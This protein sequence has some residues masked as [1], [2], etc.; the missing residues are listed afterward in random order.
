M[1]SSPAS[2]TSREPHELIES[3]TTAFPQVST[4]QDRLIAA[5]TGISAGAETRSTSSHSS[6]G[7]PP[8][9]PGVLGALDFPGP[10]PRKGEIGSGDSL[11][12]TMR[13]VA[14][15]LC[16][17]ATA[18]QASANPLRGPGEATVAG[19]AL[20]TAMSALE[21]AAKDVHRHRAIGELMGMAD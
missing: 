14:A 11:I 1:V 5:I 16:G 20:A 15:A 12:H 21:E 17:M 18:A 19:Q 6:N 7:G 3:E 9:S 10:I 8:A 4:V 2:P 13:L